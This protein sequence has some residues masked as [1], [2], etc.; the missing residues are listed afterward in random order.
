MSAVIQESTQNSKRI[1]S[2]R[3]VKKNQVES[4]I[5]VCIQE[6]ARIDRVNR[7]AVSNEFI[8]RLAQ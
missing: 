5:M 4:L 2:K 8:A 6:L 1:V 3:R 7:C